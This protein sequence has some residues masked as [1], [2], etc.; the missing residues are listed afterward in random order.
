MNTGEFE[1]RISG[2]PGNDQ[3]E[4]QC[5]LATF[6]GGM[7]DDTGEPRFEGRIAIVPFKH[8]RR[9]SCSPNRTTTCPSLVVRSY[10]WSILPAAAP[11]SLSVH[12]VRRCC[13]SRARGGHRATCD[14][15]AP[16][17]CSGLPCSACPPGQD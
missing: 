8:T 17:L 7:K 2:L 15:L 12:S 4:L 10:G 11:S 1:V 3:I 5:K 16:A 13:R 14:S 6:L 9:R